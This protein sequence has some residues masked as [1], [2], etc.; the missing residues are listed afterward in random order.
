M[1]MQRG[2]QTNLCTGGSNMSSYH[3]YAKNSTFASTEGEFDD[4]SAEI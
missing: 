3:A 2:G 4:K 1:H